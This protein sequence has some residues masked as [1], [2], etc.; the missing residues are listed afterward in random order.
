[1]SPTNKFRSSSRERGR[2]DRARPRTWTRWKRCAWKC[3]GAKASLAQISKE[4]GKLTPEE[5]ASAGKAL[6]A[7]KQE[8]ENAFEAREGGVFECK[9][10]TRGCAREWLDLTLPAPG[11]RPGQ[12]ASDHA[13]PERD[14]GPV[15]LARLRRAGR[16]G[17]GNRISQLRRAEHSARPS[18]ARHA[19]HVLAC[20]RRQPAAHAHFAGAGAR[21]GEAGAAAAHDRARA[22]CSAT[23]KWTPR[24]STRS[25]SSK[26]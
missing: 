15:H 2:A 22:A 7:A 23:K 20:E 24:T 16:A 3:W 13:H 12:P 18:G 10:C 25:I 9:R 11:P 19:G 4:F 17:S 14:R 26:A 1:M 5:R 21:H 8:L 6:N